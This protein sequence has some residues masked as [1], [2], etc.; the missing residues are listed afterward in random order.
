M[1]RLELRDVHKEFSGVEVLHGVGL[2]GDAGDV[3]GVVGAN[4]AGKSTLIKI[5]SGALPMSSGAMWMDGVRVDPRSPHDAHDL[6]IRTVYQELSLVPELSVTENLLLGAFPR[7]WGL[8]DGKAADARARELLDRVGF[9]AIDPRE[10]AGRLSV[11]RQQMVEIAKALISEPRVLILDEPS[12]VLAGADLEALFELVRLL[13]ERGVLVIYVSHRLPEVLQLATSI[14]VMKDGRVIE[15][16]APA[17]TG[18]DELIGLMAGR[19]LEQIYPARRDGRGPVLHRVVG[20]TRPG[21]FTDIGFELHAGEITGLFGLVGS[22][23]SELARC[24]FGAAP[25]AGGQGAYGSPAEAIEA[26]MALVTEDRA[27]TG[28]VLGLTV[29]DNMSLTTWYPMSR[30]PL[31]DVA[32]QR[33]DVA[34]MVD[35]LRI[36]PEGCASMPAVHLSG[37]NQQ[38]VVLAKWLL[39]EPRV[40]LLDEPTRGVDMATRVEIYRMVDELARQGL[41]VLLISSDLTEVIGATDRVLVMHQGRLTGELRSANTDEDEV[42][43][44]AMGRPV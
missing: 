36:R 4:G 39:R 26:G 17:D 22:G 3:I 20:L 33:R 31:L 25:A 21:E 43:A 34:A 35:R 24:L 37:G 6:G 2:R 32:R 29:R 28:L 5:L 30:G 12:A 7:R 18:E 19:R 11:A 44:L 14:V 23:R 41:A 42:L 1:S 38:K 16:L 8:I 10:R 13:R 15:T 9:G 27:R 40:L